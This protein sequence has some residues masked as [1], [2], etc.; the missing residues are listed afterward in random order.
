MSES[1]PLPSHGA[2]IRRATQADLPA[3]VRLYAD[4]VLG[5]AREQSTT[6]VLEAYRLAFEQICADPRQ[7]YAVLERDEEVLG[8]LQLTFVPGLI[9]VGSL[10][11][12]I[13]A[14]QIASALR[15][16]GLGEALM[17]WAVDYARGRGARL[18]E[19]TS[20]KSRI[21]AHRFYERLGFERS[22]EGFKLKL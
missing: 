20:N 17:K 22:H 13:E 16:L 4:D 6:P 3:L 15:G 5:K 21:D 10:R 14:V 12:Q 11:A 9:H 2:V 7:F 19:L 18:I 1:F 8:A